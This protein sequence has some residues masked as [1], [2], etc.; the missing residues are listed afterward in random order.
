MD[1]SSKTF[2]IFS[3]YWMCTLPDWNLHNKIIVQMNLKFCLEDH[4]QTDEPN[5]SNTISVLF[6]LS[7]RFMSHYFPSAVLKS[8]IGSFLI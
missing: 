8:G 1:N 2:S 5:K 7:F 3:M 4:Q 6:Q